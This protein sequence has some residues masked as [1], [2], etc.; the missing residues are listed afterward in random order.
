MLHREHIK[1]D[2]CVVG[3]GISG[4]CTAVAAARHGVKTVLMHERPVL[5]GNASSEIRMWICGAQGPNMRETGIMEEIHLKNFYYNPTK[6]PYVFD[7][8]LLELVQDEANITLLLNC[9][10]LDAKVEKGTFPHGRDTKITSVTGYQ[11]T[12]QTFFDVEASYFADCSGDSILAPLTGAECRIGRESR[13]EFGE[14]TYVASPDDLTMGN[15]CLIQGR[16]TENPVPFVAPK[17]ATPL[18]E[19][20]FKDRDPNLYSEWEN[21]WYLELGGNKDTIHDSEAVAKDL[22]NLAWGTWKHIKNTPKYKADNFELEFFGALPGKRESRRY[23]GEYMMKQQDVCDAPHFEDTVA[24]GGWH[25]DDHYPDGFYHQGIP[26]TDLKSNPP[27]PIPYRILYAKGVDN[28]FFAG[29]NVSCTHT[30][31]SSVRVMATCGVMGQAVGTAVSIAV[32]EGLSPHDIYLSHMMELQSTL[33]DDDCF[34]PFVIRERAKACLETPISQGDDTLKNGEDRKNRIYGDA[35]C[36]VSV[37]NGTSLSY[38]FPEGT[39]VEDVHVVFDSDLDRE[40]LP[41]GH[42]ERTHATR[43]NILKTSPLFHMPKTLCRAY[44]LT[45]T[46]QNGSTVTK[47]VEDNMTRH[48]HLPIRDTV[49]AITLTPH[50]N[51]GGTD[52]TTV[53]SFDFR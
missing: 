17:S 31:L 16:E 3:G 48:L 24:Y 21:F 46:L 5:G 33:M 36:G 23:V 12:T 15:S 50:A 38:R 41:G 42:C 7:H 37:K 29:R 40:T 1:A 39:E 47:E 52:A 8:I 44:T 34:L 22:K 28:L 19:Q 51:W 30:A 45:V 18:T 53:F 20:E 49:T 14:N 4:I 10:C 11:M 25:I 2:L 43:C 26:N 9:T 6:N 13:E 35:P 27:Y 32:R